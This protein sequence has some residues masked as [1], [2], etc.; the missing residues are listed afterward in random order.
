MMGWELAIVQWEKIIQTVDY[1]GGAE[2]AFFS[3]LKC[4]SI[5]LI[6]I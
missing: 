3:C 5:S 6:P 4:H 2:S 1:G